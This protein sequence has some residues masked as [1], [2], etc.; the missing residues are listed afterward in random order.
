MRKINYHKLNACIQLYHHYSSYYEWLS[1]LYPEWGLT[2]RDFKLKIAKD[3]VKLNSMEELYIYEF[4]KYCLNIDIKAIGLSKQ[5]KFYNEKYNENYLPDFKISKYK[6]IKLNK[7]IIIEYYGYYILWDNC[8]MIKEY[9][10]RTHRKN[11]YYKSN[12][13][14]HFIDLYPTDLKNNFEG[15]RN[16]LTSFFMDNFN[17]DIAQTSKEVS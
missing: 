12:P 8:N 9:K 14:I 6:N 3:G 15:V 17:I 4:I 5:D 11:E 1:I 2:E 13:D 10:E 7:T 16:K